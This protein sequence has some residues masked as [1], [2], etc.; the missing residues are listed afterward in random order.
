[1]GQYTHCGQKDRGI[2]GEKFEGNHRTLAGTGSRAPGLLRG[3]ARVPYNARTTGAGWI[4]V[5]ALGIRQCEGEPLTPGCQYCYE[6]FKDLRKIAEWIMPQERRPSRYEISIFDG[7]IHS[8]SKRRFRPEVVLNMKIVHREAFDQPVDE[9]EE[10]CL[11][12]MRQK[13]AELGV[14]EGNIVSTSK[15]RAMHRM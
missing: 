9:C 6:T 15:P 11:K 10:L 1:M 8:A 7:S 3:L 4:S 2:D 13:L 12:E 14:P 5:G